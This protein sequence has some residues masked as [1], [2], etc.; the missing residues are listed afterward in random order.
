[1]QLIAVVLETDHQIAQACHRI[2]PAEVVGDARGT[3]QPVRAGAADQRVTAAT[4]PR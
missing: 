3:A 2:G 4:R 1:L